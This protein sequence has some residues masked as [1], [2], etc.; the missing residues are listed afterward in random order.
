MEDVQAQSTEQEQ[1]KEVTFTPEQQSTI[2]ALIEQTKNNWEEEFLNPVV[3]ERD[4]LKTKI[5]SEPSEQE[6]ALSEREITLAQ[7]EIKIAFTE[8]GYADFADLIKVDSVEAVEETIQ[9]ITNILNPRK[10]DASYQPEDHKSQTPYE[11]ASSKSDVLGM[12][13]SKLQQAFNRN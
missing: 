13:G 6:K 2:D 8:A 5:I 1:A 7:K 10:V 11:S 3:A 4:E 12:I 9:A